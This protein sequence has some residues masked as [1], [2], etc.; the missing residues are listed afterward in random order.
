MTASQWF[1]DLRKTRKEALEAGGE[2]PRP[3]YALVE[4]GLAARMDIPN[5]ALLDASSPHPIIV[6]TTASL[7]PPSLIAML[8]EGED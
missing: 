3:F 4:A 1:S 2:A 6:I 5:G 7:T 8:F